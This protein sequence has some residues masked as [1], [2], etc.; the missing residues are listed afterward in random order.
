MP[1]ESHHRRDQQCRK[2]DSGL[3]QAEG[4][5]REAPRARA[6]TEDGA[7]QGQAAEEAGEGGGDGEGGRAEDGRQLPDPE[8]LVDEAQRAGDEE[9]EMEDHPARLTSRPSVA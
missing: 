1:V 5:E 6:L 9:E 3:Q 2:A 7:A 8:D 4:Q